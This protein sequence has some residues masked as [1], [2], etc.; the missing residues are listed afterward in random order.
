MKKG[1]K[2]I[3]VFSAAVIISAAIPEICITDYEHN[4]VVYAEDSATEDYTISYTYQ[5]VDSEAE[6]TGFSV[7]GGNSETKYRFIL[8]DEIEGVPVTKISSNAFGHCDN[9]ISVVLPE[10]LKEIGVRAFYDCNNLAEVKFNDSLEIIGDSAF[11]KSG[12]GCK[13]RNRHFLFKSAC[14]GKASGRSG[15]NQCKYVFVMLFT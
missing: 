8:P 11:N 2:I 5:I 3:T 13:S 1:L 6:I 10:N 9:L 14:F 12:F 7:D 15:R 4:T